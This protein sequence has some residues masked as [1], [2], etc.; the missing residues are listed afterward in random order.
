MTTNVTDAS[1]IRDSLLSASAG[2]RWTELTNDTEARKTGMNMVKGLTWADTTFGGNRAINPKHQFTTYGDIPLPS[3]MSRKV[4][5][6]MG[7]VYERMYERNEQRVYMQFGISIY[8]SL[9]GFF[10]NFYDASAGE[11][12]TRGVVGNFVFT[13]GKIAGYLT[14]W[15]IT[16]ILGTVNLVRNIVASAQ[17]NNLYRYFYL[18]PTMN[19]YW[20]TVQTI[21]N[22]IAVNMGFVRGFDPDELN[23]Q[24]EADLA[25]SNK[26][27]EAFDAFKGLLPDVFYGDDGDGNQ[28]NGIDV[29]RVANRYQRLA[30][31]FQSRVQAFSESLAPDQAEAALEKFLEEMTSSNQED[32]V[33]KRVDGNKDGVKYIYESS[34]MKTLIDSYKKTSLATQ[35][36]PE[37]KSDEEL[38]SILSSE[39]KVG[40]FDAAEGLSEDDDA[41]VDE[42]VGQV[43]NAKTDSRL[44]GYGAHLDAENREGSQFLCFNVD[45]VRTVSETFS[46]NTAASSVAETMNSKSEGMRGT[47]HSLSGGNI[48][49]NPLLGTVEAV[50]G[51]VKDFG[52]GVASSIGMQ[53]LYA[54]T[55]KAFV[56]IPDYVESTSASLPTNQYTIKLR[57]WC[58]HPY[59]ILTKIYYPLAC[60]LAGAAGRTTGKNSFTTPF[61]C[62]LFS[63]GRNEIEVGVIKSLSVTRGEGSVGWNGTGLPTGIDISLDV[64]NL[65][66]ALHVPIDNQV[67]PIADWIGTSTFD[68]ESPYTSYIASL[69]GQSLADRH[70]ASRRWK[71]AS[72]RKRLGWDQHFSA[73]NFTSWAISDTGFGGLSQML[74]REGIIG[75]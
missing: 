13:A 60:F 54:M 44:K 9:T 26:K 64:G 53:G 16:A 15:P 67:R 4:S 23:G 66:N 5:R 27:I 51:K 62:K 25:L 71:F 58:G 35:P 34:G 61:I 73:T 68:G 75:D 30:D 57:S 31:S 28:I 50:L 69:A 48:G 14:L 33:L 10:A 39:E 49:D 11:L 1:W 6:G 38:V 45:Y 2:R 55:G 29:I 21:L 72:R 46:T 19:A 70:H 8:N 17:N 65:S 22:G 36:N 40:V 41:N 59:S 24:S 37:A 42:V 63:Q 7:R 18:Q 20:N 3:I 32:G 47:K 56:D 52:L 43:L 74:Y 12:A